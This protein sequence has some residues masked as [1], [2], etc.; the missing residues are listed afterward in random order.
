MEN[1]NTD[2]D[3]SMESSF[4]HLL[5]P[6]PEQIQKDDF[7]RCALEDFYYSGAYY[8]MSVLSEY[9]ED[10]EKNKE[11]MAMIKKE[12]QDWIKKVKDYAK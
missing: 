1:K 5:Q 12:M 6:L 4:E 11:K 2:F 3:E 8:M 9:M 10:P 7:W